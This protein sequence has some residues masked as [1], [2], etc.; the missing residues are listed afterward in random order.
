[1][2][3][4]G[5]SDLASAVRTLSALGIPAT[6]TSLQ[7]RSSGSFSLHAEQRAE[8]LRAASRAK[9]R[10]AVV[11]VDHEPLQPAP[12]DLLDLL[13]VT[14]ISG[15][16]LLQTDPPALLAH[17]PF[18]NRHSDTLLVFPGS[19]IPVNMGSHRRAFQLCRNLAQHDHPVDILIAGSSSNRQ[20]ALPFLEQ[21]SARVIGY[22]VSR[23]HLRG[24]YFW[25]RLVEDLERKLRGLQPAPMTFSE[26]LLT[27]AKFSGRKALRRLVYS[28][29]YKNIIISY[30]WMDKIRELVPASLAR[31]VRWFCDTHDVQFIRNSTDGMIPDRMWVAP[32]AEKRR[33]VEVLNT[34]EQ[35][36]AISDGDAEALRTVLGPEKVVVAPNGF[37]YVKLDPC[38]PDLARPVFGFIGRSMEANE[39]ALT[40]I[41]TNWWPAISKHWPEAELRIAG[42]I[43]SSG[44]I[45]KNPKLA[46][47]ILLD[48]HVADLPAWYQDIDVLINPVIVRGG[49]NYKSVEALAAGRLVLTNSRGAECFADKSIL[50]VA[51]TG[52]A[53]VTLLQTLWADSNRYLT[54]LKASQEKALERFGD[55]SAISELLTSIRAPGLTKPRKSCPTKAKRVLIQAGDHHEN[56]LRLLP[57][58]R[59]I[60]Q[61]GH[62]PVVMV[63]SREN[64]P[65]LLAAGVDAVALYDYS[66]TAVEK[67]ARIASGR[68]I[69]NL[70]SP[71]RGFD[72]DDIADSAQLASPEKFSARQLRSRINELTMNID[73]VMRVVD[74]VTPDCLIVWNGYTGHTAN[75]LRCLGYQRG[76]PMFFT[77][78]SVLSDGVFI[79]PRGVNGY[80]ELATAGAE[81]LGGSYL[82][83]TR[84]PSSFLK[85]FAP[86]ELETLRASGPWRTAKRIVFVPLQ[87]QKDTNITMHSPDLKS[88]ADLVRMVHRQH[89]SSHT[90]IV[91]RPHP[92]EVGAIKIPP[93]P[94]VYVEA[95]G[96]LDAW[97]E[98][99]DLVVT[100]NSTVGMTALLRGRP[101]QSF[102]D[103]IYTGVGLTKGADISAR[104]TEAFWRL[105]ATKYLSFPESPVP[106]FL[107]E[108]LPRI[109]NQ[110][111]TRSLNPFSI[112]PDAAAKATEDLLQA[113]RS[114]AVKQGALILSHD[115]TSSDT[116]NLTYRRTAEPWNDEWMRQ[117]ARS[118][119]GLPADFPVSL[120]SGNPGMLHVFGAP[121]LATQPG[122]D[123]YFWPIPSLHK[124]T[125]S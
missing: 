55:D 4:P 112:D 14:S 47:S 91:V 22:N 52:A 85:H 106:D 29:R 57:L 39:L 59:A 76:L 38:A 43:C 79:D 19:V 77:E 117:S 121:C 109:P 49:L 65:S 102:G 119:L 94:G 101:V 53:A 54:F 8:I 89:G 125:N 27:K 51:E 111:T 63:Y 58:A 108:F 113:T 34:Y 78:R 50:A 61:R 37:D 26:N 103:G 16:Y 105:L 48:R 3:P 75:V 1:V 20:K 9:G 12:Q 95:G 110:T 6:V 18:Q 56:R 36:I 80:S 107:K 28:G 10:L 13:S 31:E 116:L 32:A 98:I 120:K 81:A 115:M 15:F 93:L 104:D 60:R 68:R 90:A 44:T 74:H 100:I 42:G 84:K 2:A 40:E 45:D 86:Q 96:D 88:M 62:H 23:Q 87:V 64:I 46:P 73:R 11:L 99:A 122:L 5:W 70:A 123:R 21:V 17:R 72:L 41:L 71:Y 69:K 7:E 66:E 97:L 67:A 83:P 114:A 118:S 30:A 82:E 25:R 35:V 24:L 33:E 124:A 92:E